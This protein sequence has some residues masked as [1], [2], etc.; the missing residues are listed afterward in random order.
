MSWY[1]EATV[2][3][4]GS[5][6]VGW[7]ASPGFSSRFDLS[8][9][10]GDCKYSWSFDGFSRKIWHN[11]IGEDWGHRWRTGSTVGTRLTLEWEDVYK[12]SSSSNNIFVSSTA[13]S[14]SDDIKKHPRLRLR[15]EYW[16]NGKRMGPQKKDLGTDEMY[17]AF[18][19]FL[20]ITN[21]VTEDADDDD[22]D[23]D[24]D[25]TDHFDG[26]NSEWCTAFQPAAT[27]HT[28][29][30][31]LGFGFGSPDSPMKY[32]NSYGD[33]TSTPVASVYQANTTNDEKNC[34]KNTV[35][36]SVTNMLV[37]DVAPSLLSTSSSSSSSS[38]SLPSTN[39]DITTFVGTKEPVLFTFVLFNP[40]GKSK[41]F[42][43]YRDSTVAFVKRMAEYWPS[44][45]FWGM[46]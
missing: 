13:A 17:Y 38:S 15:I 32:Q 27:F 19:E 36:P 23:D 26:D 12:N 29:R 14:S 31:F 41:W 39:K 37:P 45:I 33:S 7:V 10:V 18:D 4:A 11:G 43:Y 25:D 42:E 6:Q 30:A 9:A 21:P 3:S 20:T 8:A 34:T 22:D 40:R 1:Y 24:N 16:L 28:K 46:L 44:A 5:M 35:A 2:V